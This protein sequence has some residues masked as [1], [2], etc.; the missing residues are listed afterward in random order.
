MDPTR[1]RLRHPQILHLHPR[2]H[3]RGHHAQ[4]GQDIEG[5]GLEHRQE[6]AED[7][8]SPGGAEGAVGGLKRSEKVST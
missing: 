7:T 8:E 3:H 1:P 5:M 2:A 4:S 6:D